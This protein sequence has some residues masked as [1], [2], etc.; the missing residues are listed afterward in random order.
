MLQTGT[1]WYTHTSCDTVD[2]KLSI[3]NTG[4]IK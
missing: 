2:C 4:D 1:E 3:R